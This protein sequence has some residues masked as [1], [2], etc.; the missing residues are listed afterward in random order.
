MLFNIQDLFHYAIAMRDRNIFKISSKTVINFDPLHVIITITI[1]I[2]TL[3]RQAVQSPPN[4][5]TL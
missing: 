1:T 3:Y 4:R 5:C 2:T